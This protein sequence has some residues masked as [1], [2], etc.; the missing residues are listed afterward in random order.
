MT[1]TTSDA[2]ATY[3]VRLD[4]ADDADGVIPL[5][6]GTNAISIVVTAEDGATEKTYTVTVTRAAP[7]LST[8]ATLRSGLALSGIDIGAFDPAVTRLHRPGRQRRDGNYSNSGGQRR[9]GN[10]RRPTGR[11]G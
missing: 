5:S 8:D 1:A 11:A 7:P 6:V 10:L 3:A 9:R 2:N 4:G